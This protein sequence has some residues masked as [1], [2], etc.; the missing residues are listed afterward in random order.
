M[1]ARLPLSP[2]SLPPPLHLPQVAFYISFYFVVEV[3]PSLAVLYVVRHMPK[4][5]HSSDAMLPPHL[6]ISRDPS[7]RGSTDHANV[8]VI[9]DSTHF[10]PPLTESSPRHHHDGRGAAAGDGATAADG[11]PQHRWHDNAG[12][13]SYDYHH[14]S[15]PDGSSHA[16]RHT[17]AQPYAH[18]HDTR[19][20][21][22]VSPAYGRGG[23]EPQGYHDHHYPPQHGGAHHHHHQ[24]H[25]LTYSYGDGGAGASGLMLGSPLRDPTF[26]DPSTHRVDWYEQQATSPGFDDPQHRDT[27][28]GYH[29]PPQHYNEY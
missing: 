15:P 25:H 11:L 12:E 8:I 14:M 27:A 6:Q 29:P 28:A 20:R 19:P 3:T 1:G 21:G 16:A 13:A 5:H 9:E 7:S 10:L 24:S 17:H 4:R 23:D 18:H 22:A 26:A 2:L